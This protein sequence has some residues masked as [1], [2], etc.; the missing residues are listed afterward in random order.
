VQLP[1]YRLPIPTAN[2]V[3]QVRVV[4][5]RNGQHYINGSKLA[6]S[7]VSGDYHIL[8]V[9]SG[10]SFYVKTADF[11]KLPGAKPRR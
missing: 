6:S 3:G 8:T 1:I 11:R 9:E 2:R 10:E 7:T 5:D 4:T